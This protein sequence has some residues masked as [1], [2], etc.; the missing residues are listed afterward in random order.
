MW[1]LLL[2]LQVHLFLFLQPPF[3][4]AFMSDN[5]LQVLRAL[6]LMHHHVGRVLVDASQ[7]GSEH[8]AI[9]QACTLCHLIPIRSIEHILPGAWSS[10]G[11]AT[12][13]E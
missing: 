10:S 1:T 7:A 11:V 9:R 6:G 3:L 8:E 12:A 4:L 5:H 2:W 13:P